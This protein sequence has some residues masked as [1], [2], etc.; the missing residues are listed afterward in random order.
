MRK[1]IITVSGRECGGFDNAVRYH[2]RARQIWD[3]IKAKASHCAWPVGPKAR[4]TPTAIC[5]RQSI[6]AFDWEGDDTG[7]PAAPSM[8]ARWNAKRLRQAPGNSGNQGN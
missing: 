8:V 3:A 7:I 2:D 6:P 4:N 5:Q 1:I